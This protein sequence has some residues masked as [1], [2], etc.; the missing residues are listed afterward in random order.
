M[1]EGLVIIWDVGLLDGVNVLLVFYGNICLFLIEC[2]GE[3][4]YDI[5]EWLVNGSLF[6]LVMDGDWVSVEFYNY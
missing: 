5:I 4:K 1:N 3:G 6:K 2:F